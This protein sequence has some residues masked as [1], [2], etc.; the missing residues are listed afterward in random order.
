V[1]GV[2]FFTPFT[3]EFKTHL[4]HKKGGIRVMAK[5]IANPEK[6][7]AEIALQQSKIE[8]LKLLDAELAKK[9]ERLN[10][11]RKQVQ[12]KIQKLN[13]AY[14]QNVLRFKSIQGT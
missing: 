13:H 1:T 6:L 7:R 3:F 5:K 8:T 11:Q 9:V 10:F 2:E 4:S 12:E 14:Q